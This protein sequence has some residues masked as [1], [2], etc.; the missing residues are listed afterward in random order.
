MLQKY[1]DKPGGTGAR[2]EAE[3]A[4]T[5]EAVNQNV[6]RIVDALERLG[7]DD[8]TIVIFH[9]D[10]GGNRQY[11]GPLA[12]ERSGSAGKDRGRPAKFTE[13]NIVGIRELLL[14]GYHRREVC[15]ELGTHH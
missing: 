11:V 14:K 4:A 6:G 13:V 9:S 10:N 5:V 12:D 2:E 8:D 3:Y 15:R 1:R 7:L